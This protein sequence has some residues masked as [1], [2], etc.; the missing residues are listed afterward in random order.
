MMKKLNQFFLAFCL[1]LTLPI[2][3]FAQREMESLGR[4]VVA[5]HMIGDSVFVSWRLLGNDPDDI[6][7]N[8][9]RKTDT[10][11]SIKLNQNPITGA[12]IF[13]DKSVDFTKKNEWFVKPVLNR[14]EELESTS[15]AL[16]SGSEAKPY[17]S[18]PLKTQRGYTPNDISVG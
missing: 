6:S 16:Q 14:K 2:S 1:W 12:T 7:F 9:Y 3:L 5:I 4:G 17:L 15:F 10:S 11:T 8:I 13:T 18:V